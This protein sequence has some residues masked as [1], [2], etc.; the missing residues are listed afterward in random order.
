MVKLKMNKI[1]TMGHRARYN[2]YL[3]LYLDYVNN[4]LTLT[5]FAE[6]YDIEKS[7]ARTFLDMGELINENYDLIFGE[8]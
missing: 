8:E 1:P 4:Y 2:L 7:I 6:S 3:D 5:T